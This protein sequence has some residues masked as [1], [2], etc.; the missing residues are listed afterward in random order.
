MQAVKKIYKPK[1]RKYQWLYSIEVPIV[2]AICIV[3]SY[4]FNASILLWIVPFLIFV[5][6]PF[7]DH[8]SPLDLSNPEDI[9][10][11]I[12]PLRSY[13]EWIVRSYVPLQWGANLA[14]VWYF[15]QMPLDLWQLSG[16]VLTVG[17]TNGLGINVA[18]EVN[19]KF[20][21]V[22]RIFG[23][24]AIAPTF[25]GQ[26]LIEHNRGHH[27]NV[28]TPR[29]P[30]SSRMG[31]PFWTF[32]VRSISLGLLSACRLELARVTRD[33]RPLLKLVT[34][35]L[36]WSWIVSGLLFGAVYGW[37]GS[38]TLVFFVAQAL[39]GVLL[40]E[41]VN[42][43][44]H[45]GLLRKR[46]DE[47]YERCAPE[48]SWNS[49]KLVSNMGL[50]NL[51]RHSDHHA[52][53]SRPYELLRHFETAPQLP[54]GYAAMIVLALFPPLWFRVMD[55]RVLAHYEGDIGRAHLLP[56]KARQLVMRYSVREQVQVV[57]AVHSPALPEET[58]RQA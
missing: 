15:V 22:S 2:A 23:V 33:S 58:R 39:I 42:Y 34:S 18:H 51:Q 13:F 11:D 8:R 56:R 57:Q 31:E 19:H 29:D 6:I 16:L 54:S 3:A 47:R 38:A 27:I 40:L 5:V 48:H 43:V 35:Q 12:K 4:L 10:I 28:A 32:S 17:I 37:G 55:P 41:A 20:S 9:A 36:L 44:E 26:F 21:R 50:F 45:Y 52:N 14:G 7:M 49:N 24:F 30:A 53:S 1:L 25:Y 46:I